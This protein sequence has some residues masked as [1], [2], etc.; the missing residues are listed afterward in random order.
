MIWRA[1]QSSLRAIRG[2]SGSFRPVTRQAG[3]GLAASLNRYEV[4]PFALLLPNVRCSQNCSGQS[5]QNPPRSNDSRL[6]SPNGSVQSSCKSQISTSFKIC[7][8]LVRDQ[9]VGGSNPLSPTIQII[10]LHP[11][12]RLSKT[13]VQIRIDTAFL[14]VQQLWPLTTPCVACSINCIERN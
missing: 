7:L 6:A 4:P 14:T 10:Y 1:V 5:F 11:I 8:H 9:G 12:S 13:P 2:R 3:N